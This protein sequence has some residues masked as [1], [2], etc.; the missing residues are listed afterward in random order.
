MSMEKSFLTL[1]FQFRSVELYV[2]L[3]TPLYET[4]RATIVVSM[5]SYID[6]YVIDNG[7]APFGKM[8]IFITPLTHLAFPPHRTLFSFRSVFITQKLARDFLSRLS[9]Q[10]RNS[11]GFFYI[12]L[13]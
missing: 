9:V 2:L 5:I 6:K 10:S 8:I 7:V 4:L 11:R 13:G 12:C 3:L 1:V